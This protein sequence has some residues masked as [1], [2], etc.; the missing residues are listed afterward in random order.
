MYKS[1]AFG[2]QFDYFFHMH[3][4]DPITTLDDDV[5]EVLR[6]PG[7]SAV[8]LL[9]LVD[10]EVAYERYAGV[11]RRWHAPWYPTLHP[12]APVDAG[13]RFDLASLT[14]P[15]VAAALLVELEARG[16]PP[17]TALRDILPESDADAEV[18]DLL[19]HTAGYPAEWPDRRPDR[20]AARFRA[21]SRPERP[22]REGYEYSCVGYI[23]AGLA[24]EA[25]A[26]EPLDEAVARRVLAPLGMEGAGYRPDPRQRDRIAATEWQPGRGLVH[27]EVHDEVSRALGGVTG[28]AGLFGTARDVARFADALR[29][30]RGGG[31]ALPPGVVARLTRPL[32]IP[33]DP[34][35]R[36]ALGPR[37]GEPWARALGADAVGHTGFTGTAFA[38]RPDGRTSVVFLTNRVHPTRRSTEVAAL[39]ARVVDHAALLGGTP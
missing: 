21:R 33:G 36:Q 1:V 6:S 27:A 26:G 37:V 30:G 38:T 16:I 15:I 23:W 10:G 11:V 8:A 4:I 13:T 25:L 22:R 32:G 35:Y 24:L 9:V 12:A 2:K 19:A 3:R 34:G 18:G 5:D 28:N 20:D 39:R 17:E 14:K 29:T 31:S 7:G